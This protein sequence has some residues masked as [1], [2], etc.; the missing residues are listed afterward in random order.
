[1]EHTLKI[2]PIK[3][4]EYATKRLLCGENAIK[5]NDET[6]PKSPIYNGKSRKISASLK[7]ASFCAK[8]APFKCEI[9]RTTTAIITTAT[10]C[11]SRTIVKISNE[12]LPPR[13]AEIVSTLFGSSVGILM[14]LWTV[15][16]LPKVLCNK[17]ECMHL[18]A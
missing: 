2:I 15:F 16:A 17:L 1:M 3:V 10:T 9:L 11:M 8:V 12:I 5:T 14:P 18:P 4:D 6:D 13:S 7:A